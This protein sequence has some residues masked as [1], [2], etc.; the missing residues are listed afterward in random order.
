MR[1]ARIDAGAMSD[2]AR[3]DG[4]ITRHDGSRWSSRERACKGFD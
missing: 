1:P 4:V 2:L 3:I